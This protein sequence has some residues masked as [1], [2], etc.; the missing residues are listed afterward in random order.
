MTIFSEQCIQAVNSAVISSGF[1]PF[2]FELVQGKKE[3]YW[4]S[5]PSQEKPFLELYV[6]TNE[7]GYMLNGSVW[8]IF[9]RPDFATEQELIHRFVG[10][11]IDK[12]ARE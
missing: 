12:L 3:D 10:A 5:K 4:H 11:V 7:A 9:E 2:D 6:Y 1:S 8:I